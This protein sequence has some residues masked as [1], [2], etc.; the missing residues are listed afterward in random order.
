MDISGENAPFI[1]RFSKYMH[2]PNPRIIRGGPTRRAA[3]SAPDISK[4]SSGVKSGL[5]FYSKF[6]FNKGLPTFNYFKLKPGSLSKSSRYHFIKTTDISVCGSLAP[7]K[8]IFSLDDESAVNRFI[9]IINHSRN[10]NF[11]N[12]L[13]HLEEISAVLPPEK[14]LKTI[15]KGEIMITSFINGNENRLISFL[16]NDMNI[17]TI[18]ALPFENTLLI[19]AE[20]NDTAKLEALVS[21]SL[22]K[23]VESTGQIELKE[24]YIMHEPLPLNCVITRDIDRSYPKAALIDSGV[25]DNSLLKEWEISTEKYIADDKRNTAHGTFVCG[26]MLKNGDEFG[27]ILYL[28]VEMIPSDGRISIDCFYRNMKDLL[29]KYASTIKIYNI[30]LG[31]SSEITEEFSYGAYIF[32]I[33]QKE[34]DVLFIITA[35]NSSPDKELSFPITSPAESIHSITVGAVAHTD[36]NIQ[37]K[38]SPSLFTR[39]G[40]APLGFIKPDIAAYGGAH[41]EH[42]GR[43]KPVGVFS[44]GIRNELA[45]DIGTSHAAPLVTSAAAKIYHRYSHAFK[46]PDITKAMLI[47]DTFINQIENKPDIFTGYGILKEEKQSD[48]VTYLHEGIVKPESI[49][50]LPEIPIPPDM[51]KDG[52]ITGSI[53]LT[54][55]YKTDINIA[56]PHYYSMT[57]LDISL[58]YYENNSW[59]SLLT[60]KNA[61]GT[62]KGKDAQELFRWQ[63]VKVYKKTFSKKNAPEK[64]LLRIIPNKRDFYN[65]LDPISYSF[66]LSFTSQ[67]ENLYEGILKRESEYSHILENSSDM[68]KTC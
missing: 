54:L 51:I 62:P 34:Y 67:G 22:V 1:L 15:S 10:Q 66:A 40:P 59:K 35:G 12:S 48:H 4:I 65:K 52:K 27:N 11:R 29:E 21:H 26:R 41:A 45:E 6:E 24:Q 33:L 53:I 7:D 56:F 5:N 14:I 43:L 17:R 20:L 3:G 58:G 13:T 55:V 57:M 30:S 2:R 49:V 64:L 23:S 9:N 63:P 38:H 50:E 31:T 46:S 60:R 25:S 44:I 37:K 61:I 42:F 36:T 47:H 16:E 68:W 19:R 39:H 8:L 28:N 32:D 18:D